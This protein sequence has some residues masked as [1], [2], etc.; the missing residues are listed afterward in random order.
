[1]GT[2]VHMIVETQQRNGKWKYV[3]EL[4][5]DRNY[6]F[7]DF[8]ANVRGSSYYPLVDNLRSTLPADLSE[9]ALQKIA[10]GKCDDPLV[11]N[12]GLFLGEYGFGTL[13]LETFKKHRWKH[14]WKKYLHYNTEFG[15]EDTNYG[16]LFNISRMLFALISHGTR[17][18]RIVFG[19][20]S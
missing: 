12:Q 7:F 5:M 3:E 16:V 20:D 1:M 15:E 9:E 13:T 14:V 19:F 18:T 10:Q 2:D 8:L 6:E 11:Y 17:P 4:G